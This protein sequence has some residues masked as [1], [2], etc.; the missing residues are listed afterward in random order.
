MPQKLAALQQRLGYEFRSAPL[1][2]E[3][4]TH[5]SYLQDHPKAGPHNQR[6]EFLGEHAVVARPHV[7][8]RRGRSGKAENSFAGERHAARCEPGAAER[9]R[10]S[11]G[12]GALALFTD[13]PRE[14]I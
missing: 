3:A 4:L 5:P 13:K 12:A 14:V 9:E 8:R 1:L 7:D 10:Q 6:L 11:A 2:L